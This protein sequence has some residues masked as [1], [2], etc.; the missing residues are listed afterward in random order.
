M[1]TAAKEA[2]SSGFSENPPYEY[3]APW[4]DIVTIG[5]RIMYLMTVKCGIVFY[6]VGR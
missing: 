3:D 1:G 5:I 4:I 6:V 2:G